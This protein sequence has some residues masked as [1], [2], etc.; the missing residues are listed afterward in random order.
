[1]CDTLSYKQHERENMKAKDKATV[2]NP[3]HPHKGRTG[4]IANITKDSEGTLVFIDFGDGQQV[5]VEPSDI[6]VKA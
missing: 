6:K 3:F 5:M 1:M 2:I 4:V